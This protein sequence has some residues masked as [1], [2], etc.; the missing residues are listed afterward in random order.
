MATPVQPHLFS[1]P[2]V[3]HCNKQLRFTPEVSCKFIEAINMDR[4][5]D[6]NLSG[7]AVS[8][9]RGAADLNL[10]DQCLALSCRMHVAAYRFILHQ[11]CRRQ[12]V[13]F[14]N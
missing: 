2:A 4:V 1:F 6:T 10:H 9:C 7:I 3:A 14:S 5:N 8:Y 11:P 12:N 13:S